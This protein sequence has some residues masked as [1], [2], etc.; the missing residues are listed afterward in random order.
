MYTSH[1]LRTPQGLD[2]HHLRYAGAGPALLLLH[3]LTANAH[4]FSGLVT[5]G[6]TEGF[7][8]ISVDLRGR[9]LSDQPAHRYS[10]ADHADDI[11]ALLESLQLESVH[12][13]GHSF[14][15][16][17]G[18]YLAAHFPQRVRRLVLLDAAMQMNRRT[19]EML[20]PRLAMLDHVFPSWDGYLEAVKAAPFLDFWDDAMLEYY[21]ADV[22]EVE[23]GVTPRPTLA[24]MLA[25]SKGLSEQP[26]KTMLGGIAQPTLLV[27]AHDAYTMGEPLLWEHDA[28]E[29]VE[30]LP[31]AR[32]AAVSGNHQ[33]MLYGSG[34]KETTALVRQFLQEP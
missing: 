17:L 18:L 23:G 16:F 20:M 13:C 11:V 6:L 21:R 25:A 34:A 22:K 3:G 31:N 9:G 14:G 10:M 8:V 4:A 7:N 5:A 32:Y 26:W 28:R 33:T 12:I 19:A 15:G 1:F 24:N 30:A 2:L 27:H 29:T